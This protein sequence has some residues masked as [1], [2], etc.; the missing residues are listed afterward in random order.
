MV[1]GL[2]RFFARKSRKPTIDEMVPPPEMD[3]VG[4]GDFKALGAAMTR[5][6]INH[7]D[8]SLRPD[9]P[10]LDIGCGLGRVAIHLTQYL[11]ADT[12]FEGF[13]VDKKAIS[14]CRKRIAPYYPN[15]HF[16]CVDLRNTYYNRGGSL[17]ASEFCFPFEDASFSFAFATSVFTHLLPDTV[18]RYLGEVFRTLRPGGRFLATFFLYT[19]EMEPSL[20]GGHSKIPLQYKK[21][22]N[23]LI[24]DPNS[25]EAVVAY[26]EDFI[27]E[28]YARARLRVIPPIGYGDWAG[29]NNG[30]AG[31]QD[32]IIAVKD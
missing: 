9:D 17:N 15:F 24:G 20:L 16:T 3:T 22:G 28:L 13:D 27:G 4:G 5:T 29:R 10:T 7:P 32:Q 2:R 26:R 23:F 8:C 6:L 14:Y 31:F 18:E 25:A 19:A 11:N 1:V 21:D 12:R 30:P